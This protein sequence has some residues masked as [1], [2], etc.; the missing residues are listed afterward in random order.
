MA[1]LEAMSEN[2]EEVLEFQKKL[3]ADGRATLGGEG[4]EITKGM[5]SWTKGTKKISEI[6]YTPSVI[7]PSFGEES[8]HESSCFDVTYSSSARV[9]KEFG[10]CFGVYVLLRSR[11]HESRP[12]TCVGVGV[13]IK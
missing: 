6:K 8:T 5:C 13:G 1:A 9:S 3:E 12:P 4:F 7:E 11:I 10:L 2:E